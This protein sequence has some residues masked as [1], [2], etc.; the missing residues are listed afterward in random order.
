MSAG[1]SANLIRTEEI[2]ISK[3][4]PSYCSTKTGLRLSGQ[5]LTG[6]RPTNMEL[7]LK[8][9]TVFCYETIAELTLTQEETLESIVPDACPDILRIIDVCGQTFVAGKQVEEGRVTVS[10]NVAAVL[11][12]QPDQQSGVCRMEITLPFT[13]KAE[14]ELLKPA[15]IVHTTARLRFMDARILN[16]RKVLIRSDI[17]VDVMAFQSAVHTTALNSNQIREERLLK[18]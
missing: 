12:Y 6:E 17:L 14:I 7:E 1:D 18:Y 4:T 10:G 8:K 11:L 9:D 2:D 13:C 5:I 16:P 15:D 3:E